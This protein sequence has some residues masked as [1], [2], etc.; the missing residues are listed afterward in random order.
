MNRSTLWNIV[1]AVGIFVVAAFMMNPPSPSQKNS[2]PRMEYSEL[3]QLIEKDPA[4]I[5]SLTVINGKNEVRVERPNSAPVM[6]TVPSKAGEARLIEKAG[7]KNVKVVAREASQ[8]VTAGETFA[9]IIVGLI[10]WLLIFGIFWYLMR[11]MQGG[12]VSQMTEFT[13]SKRRTQKPEDIKTFKDVEGCDE[14]KEEAQ[15]IIDFLKDPHLFK[16]F[17]GRPPRG[18]LLVGP[19]GTGKTLLAKA[20]AGEAGASFHEV[21]ASQFVEMFVGVGAARVRDLFAEARKNLPA[22]IFIDELDAVGRQRGA[23]VGGGNDE[24]EQTLNQLLTEMDGFNSNS[25]I[26][27]MAATNRPDVLD[28][29]LIRPGRFDRQI[30][31]DVPDV[32]GRENIFKVHT[33]NKPL[34]ADVNVR[35]L[36]ERTPGFSGAEIEGACNE[37]ATVAR[38]RVAALIKEMETSGS[39]KKDIKAVPVEITRH[40]FDEGIDRVT[41][42]VAKTTRAKTMSRESMKNTSIHE[43]GHALLSE[44]L[45]HGDPVTKITIVPRSRALGYVQALPAG[46]RYTYTVEQLQARIIMAMGGRAA[47]EVLLGA[48]D[49]GASNDFQQAYGIARRMVME[50]GMSRLGPLSVSGNNS[51]PFLG[52]SMAMPAEAG[53]AMTD[54]IDREIRCIVSYCLNKAKEL[55]NSHRNFILAAN[56]VLMKQETLLG[57]DW[58]ALLAEHGITTHSVEVTIDCQNPCHVNRVEEAA[59]DHKAGGCH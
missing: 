35:E 16:R 10:P 31:V 29:A 23:G 12:G 41:M 13:K 24:R 53:P 1:F 14:A 9:N 19:P 34:A 50:W 51:N 8:E 2:V 52:K 5:Q 54:E 42:G 22:I 40:D 27:M 44:L 37:A 15:E 18:V 4:S 47:Q 25:G 28:P 59:A 49:T 57:S 7:E 21:T 39:T 30:S 56:E 6:V 38:R 20:I 32:K 55:V 3:V 48:V 46:D 43:L 11:R 58:R 33:R 26:V 45:K 36:A 17:G